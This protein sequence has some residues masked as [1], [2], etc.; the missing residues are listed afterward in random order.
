[1]E[2]NRD[3]FHF[4]FGFVGMVS[5]GMS[6][7]VAVGFYQVEIAG[8]RNVSATNERSGAVLVP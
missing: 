6:V 4:L 5:L 2:F 3:L 8:S 7:L 1:M